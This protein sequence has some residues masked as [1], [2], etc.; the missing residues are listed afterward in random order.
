MKN[1]IKRF[2]V[3]LVFFL[4]Y[5]SFIYS[6]PIG[7]GEFMIVNL[8]GNTPITV[9]IYPVGAIF[10]GGGQYTVDA[11]YAIDIQQGNTYIYPQ[12]P[13]VLDY[14]QSG[15]DYYVKA[16]FDATEERV[17]CSFSLGYGAY[18]IKFY[19][20]DVFK[21]DCIVDFSD[22]NFK[23]V[24][25]IPGYIQKLK[26]NYYEWNNIKFQFLD[27]N[28]STNEVNINTVG[29]NIRVWEQKGTP[30]ENTLTPSKGNFNDTV[31]YHDYPI[32]AR[33]FSA[34][35]HET[36]NVIVLNL[37][38]KYP[39]ANTKENNVLTF[40]NCEF[41][42]LDG[43]TYT[44]NSNEYMLI[45]GEGG[46]FISGEG[47]QIIF[48]ENFEMKITNYAS[49]EAIGTTFRT[50]NPLVHWFRIYLVHPENSVITG[51][52]LSYASVPIW[53]NQNYLQSFN[54]I[55][56]TF[57]NNLSRCII[58]DD[59]YNLNI[60]GNHFFL[61]NYICNEQVYNGIVITDFANSEED[62][63]S[64]PWDWYRINIIGNDFHGGKYHILANSTELL[65]VYI[66]DNDFYNCVSNLYLVNTVGKISN[67]R[68]T[69][70]SYY[71]CSLGS[72]HLIGSSSDFLNNQ[73]TSYNNFYLD[74]SSNPNF[75][76]LQENNQY[77]WKGGKNIL[78]TSLRNIETSYLPTANFITNNGKNEFHIPDQ[79]Y[80]HF[81]GALNMTETIYKSNCNDWFG[82]NGIPHSNLTNINNDP[83][84]VIY[85][86]GGDCNFD[87]QIVDRIIKDMGNGIYD[88]ILITQSNSNP[89][90][91]NDE[92]FYA[93]GVKN[94][95]LKNY[96]SAISNIKNLIN[97]YPN[98]KYLKR[99]I[100]NL[101]EC[102]VLS[103]T[104]HN[105]GWRNIIF[106]DLKNYLEDKIQ[107]YQNNAEFVSVAF[108][109]VLK[110]KIKIKSYTPAMDGYEFIATNSPSATERLMASIN[111]IDVEGLLPGQGG[112]VKEFN[113]SLNNIEKINTSE[114]IRPIKD[115]LLNAYS[116]TTKSIKQKEESELKN[117]KDI[118]KTEYNLDK[119][120][121]SDKILQNRAI[122]N[123]RISGSLD[124]K[125]RRE[126]IRNELSLLSRGESFDVSI[127]EPKSNP[128]DYSLSQN[129]P[130][131]FN[132]IT[133]IRYSIKDQKLVTLKI[134]DILGREVKTLVNEVKTPGEYLVE[135]NGSE[136]SSGIYFYRIVVGD[137]TAVKRMV[138]I[139]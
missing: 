103:D 61:Q 77:I 135:F 15:N 78:Q 28:V 108:D 12:V 39:G 9:K 4:L 49:I 31:T 131:P 104:N 68:I 123:I 43:I 119:K 93:T 13:I 60:T 82:F 47:S 10:S 129:Y 45:Q 125:Q 16:N 99:S 127:E 53:I 133:N 74:G 111:Y 137:F 134:Y 40:S 71:E 55:G 136:L 124:K 100:Y 130:N 57:H 105:Q 84:T 106:G 48:P 96:S 121:K 63:N 36:F 44:V 54:I 37:K 117:S 3:I 128:L 85:D 18:K 69:N 115:I 25:I 132:P 113:N 64:A 7:D 26:I 81:Y 109:F 59:I 66:N 5:S 116:K 114:N 110:C 80:H 46:K 91:G 107:Q 95:D 73:I 120:H 35:D 122:N 14:N 50:D 67:N 29:N 101:Y 23:G 98:S 24:S 76:P 89:P 33:Q 70:A 79:Y 118:S 30:Y 86:Q 112:G 62:N 11:K 83:V 72:V 8:T 17:G 51:C 94:Q 22:A 138:L 38:I 20:N 2:F 90:P 21:N 56:N 42:I 102:Y 65:P 34:I 126:R 87:N 97:T 139:K 32:D 52:T 19:E 41:K 6:Q 27:E 1:S 88:T 58:A 75:A 92:S